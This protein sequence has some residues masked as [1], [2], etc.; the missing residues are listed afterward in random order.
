MLEAKDATRKAAQVATIGRRRLVRPATVTAAPGGWAL[1]ATALLAAD[2]IA[3]VVAVVLATRLWSAAPGALTWAVPLA[4][5][6]TFVLFGL[7]DRRRLGTPS[8]E[9]GGVVKATAAATA[10]VGLL[11]VP[12]ASRGWL[13]GLALSGLGLFG[14]SRWAGRRARRLLGDVTEVLVVGT[15]DRAR[16]VARALGRG[17]WLGYRTL[18]FVQAGPNAFG[19]IDGFPILGSADRLDEILTET[20]AGAVV[21]AVES[22]PPTARGGVHELLGGRGIEVWSIPSPETLPA[23]RVRLDTLDETALLEVRTPRRSP[24]ELATKRVL[25]VA[26]AGLLLALTSP[27]TAVIAAAIK[28]TSPG[29][30][31]FRQVRVGQG[32]R[33]FVLHKFRTMVEGAEAKLDELSERNEADGVL[34]KLRDDPRVTAVGRLLRRTSLDEL[35]QLLNVLRGE[36][37]LVGPRP[38]LPEETDR[39]SGELRERLRVKPGLTGL[40]QVNGRQELTFA[41]YVHYDLLYAEH[42]SLGLDFRVLARTIPAVLSGRGSW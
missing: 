6:A 21:L 7:Y 38:A 15:D 19:R 24:V 9:A 34:F 23:G 32:G 36:M 20:G 2:A 41:D 27:L 17:R 39:Y 11:L 30:I 4:F 29:P 37:S 5:P 26:G 16:A 13:L 31:L 12:D 1:T 18:G 42:W 28:L 35:P 8:A 25:D 22:I 14:V 33:R 40:W 3:A 10:V